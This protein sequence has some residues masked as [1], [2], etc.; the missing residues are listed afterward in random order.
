M[1]PSRLAFLQEF[2][3]ELG[4]TSL[5]DWFEWA[6]E[7]EPVLDEFIDPVTLRRFLQAEDRYPRKPQGWQALVRNFQIDPEPAR[8]FL[9]G[10]L[11]PVLGH[12][13]ERF[14]GDD[15]DAEDLWQETITCA[16]AALS[17][18]KLPQRRAV[19]S[20][21][22]L[23]PFSGLRHWLRREISRAKNA[24]P[25]PEQISAPVG[26]R[27][28]ARLRDE[29][30]LAR[31][32]RRAGLDREGYVLLRLLRLHGQPLTELA[33]AGSATYQRLRRRFIEAETRLKSWLVEHPHWPKENPNGASD[34]KNDLTP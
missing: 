4:S 23:D 26:S 29:L 8:V 14:T 27:P 9:L 15:L 7:R 2:E 24:I 19:L 11:E 18:P 28:Q 1:T 12:L 3:R 33:P 32:C 16:L 30:V 34:V 25:M 5:R 17:N 22:R 21:L 6:R 20:G 31:L 13:M 10:L